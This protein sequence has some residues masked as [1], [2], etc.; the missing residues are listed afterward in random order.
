MQLKST[1]EQTTMDVRRRPQFVGRSAVYRALTS[2]P[3][4]FKKRSDSFIAPTV[5]DVVPTGKDFIRRRLSTQSAEFTSVKQ[6]FRNTIP[7]STAAIIRIE[8]VQNV[9]LWEHYQG[10]K[11][12]MERKRP[13]CEMEKQLFHG[14]EM[15]SIQHICKHNFDF[16]VSGKNGTLFGQGTYFAKKASFSDKYSVT[17]K[18][19]YQFMFLAKVLVGRSA[20]GDPSYKRPPEIENSKGDLYDSCVNSLNKPSRFVIFDRYQCYPEYLI[21][22]T[23]VSCE[24]NDVKVD[25]GNLMCSPG[26]S[27]AGTKSKSPQTGPQ[28]PISSDCPPQQ[29]SIV[30][31]ISDQ[32]H[33]IQMQHQTRAGEPQHSSSGSVILITSTSHQCGTEYDPSIVSQQQSPSTDNLTASQSIQSCTDETSLCVNDSRQSHG[34]ITIHSLPRGDNPKQSHTNER[35][36]PCSVM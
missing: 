35:A 17:D 19:G 5:W 28:H 33:H 13:G 32:R 27:N 12:H 36:S 16:R 34:S 2:H 11:K 9:E 25:D 30:C 21:T 31:D 22:Y 6:L 24:K 3:V 15:E 1:N 10:M 8:R 20:K 7:P 29:S 23:K 4:F 26:L 18:S 14:T